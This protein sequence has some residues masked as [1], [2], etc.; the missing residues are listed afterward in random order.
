MSLYS[1]VGGFGDLG[2]MDPRELR[3]IARAL[4][5][6]ALGIYRSGINYPLQGVGFDSNTLSPNGELSPLV[7]Q[8]FQNTLDSTTF[9][10]EDIVLWPRLAA[11]SVDATSP[12]HEYPLV[13]QYGSYGVDPFFA[14]GGIVGTSEAAFER[15]T[16]RVKYLMEVIT[17]TDVAIMTGLAQPNPSALALRTNQGTLSLT[18]KLETLCLHADSA[19]NPNHF[20]G[21]IPS[22]R[23]GAP[24]NHTD[25]QGEQATP[26]KLQEIV[27]TMVQPPLYGRPNVAFCDYGVFTTLANQASTYG[28]HD[29]MV[30]QNGQRGLYWGFDKL[31]LGTPYGRVELVPM[32]FLNERNTPMPRAMGDGAP[33]VPVF[34]VSEVSISASASKW[35]TTD[36]NYAYWYIA[37][38]YGDRGTCVTSPFGGA[39]LTATDK[40]MQIDAA[41]SGYAMSG[42]GGGRYYKL[43]RARVAAGAPAPTDISA[44]ELV[45]SHARNTSNAGATRVS[46]V[47]ARKPGT[48]FI[49]F[50]T[51]RQ[52][53]IQ[54][55][56][57]LPFT[58]RNFPTLD[59]TMKFG[60][61]LFGAVTMKVPT[62]W[63]I[64]ENVART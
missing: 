18:Q 11:M 1:P 9:T 48:S 17:L 15:K 2:E 3:E 28:R 62:K 40:A 6:N 38:F 51:M 47:G 56:K 29:Q 8:S 19:L 64:G 34:S 58:R 26:Q 59:T 45:A 24:N 25:F 23:R 10:E 21:I 54:W 63:W 55:T 7:P 4:E 37:E 52:D 31:Y 5:D 39:T 13:H 61:M 32:P 30:Q 41:D 50:A 16:V 46:D 14:E 27:G 57:Y 43:Y 44:Y 42:S 53:T 36:I 35:R 49:V 60:L 33:T 22:I 12:L 20:D